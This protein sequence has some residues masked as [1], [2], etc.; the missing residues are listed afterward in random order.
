M[1]LGNRRGLSPARRV[2]SFFWD[3]KND[4][5]E[6]SLTLTVVAD[7]SAASDHVTVRSAERL[8]GR[9][10]QGALTLEVGHQT[11]SDPDGPGWTGVPH[12]W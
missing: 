7:E 1:F 9:M 5:D 11:H 10:R 3:V 2:R 8:P 4:A 6:T 12:R